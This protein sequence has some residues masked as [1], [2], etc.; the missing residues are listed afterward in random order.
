MSEWTTVKLGDVVECLDAV[1]RPVRA[2]ER[3]P[4]PYP[5]Y[6]ASGVIDHVDEYL[7]EGTYTLVAEDGENLRSRKTPIAFL[8]RGRFW[9]NNHAHVL[10]GTPD[11][12]VRYLAYRLQHADVS[13][14]L[15]GSTQPKLTQQALLSMRFPWPPRDEQDA[16]A[17]VLGALDNK[18]ECNLR[19]ARITEDLAVALVARLDGAVDLSVIA[20][21]NGRQVKTTDFS[22]EM[23]DYFSLPAFDAA[24]LPEYCAGV[25][26]KSNKL[27]LTEPVVLVSR[28][29]PH[30]P[31]IWH[32]IPRTGYMA[33]ASTEFVALRPR[34]GLTSEELWAA[35][36][37]DAFTTAL[38]ERVTGTTGSHQRIRP[39]DVLQV[40][41][42]DP[43]TASEDTRMAVRALVD[44][45][46]SAR[47][48]S[49]HV[50]SF[51][52]ALL[53]PLLSGH[54]PVRQVEALAGEAL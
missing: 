50:A 10:A 48:E 53:P 22:V 24:A 4:G 49:L 15:S 51:R 37:G 41:V 29:N 3:R 11:T 43:R 19:V 26:I 28:L 13:G 46:H 36:A 23:V 52:D 54:L 42:S 38:S 40:Q 5:Y 27:L 17:E 18:I 2:R 16:I 21:P 30:I 31:R 25:S 39:E 35:C 32:A 34:E 12:D 1:R 44:R 47:Q 7:L 9:V 6:G 33:L 8:A 14:Y 45:A 20:Q